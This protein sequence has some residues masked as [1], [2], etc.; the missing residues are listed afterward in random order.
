MFAKATDRD[1]G[2]VRTPSHSSP[3]CDPGR[4]L[5]KQGLVRASLPCQ[6]VT[7]LTNPG[8]TSSG[9]KTSEPT[10]HNLN[11]AQ[12]CTYRLQ[13]QAGDPAPSRGY[14]DTGA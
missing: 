4:S 5:E 9:V 1:L 14:V 7:E 8:L 13:R 10:K 11:T 3:I 6:M 2:L 12:T